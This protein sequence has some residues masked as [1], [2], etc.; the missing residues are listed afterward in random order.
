MRK[1]NKLVQGVGVNDADYKII[2]CQFYRRWKSMLLRC[3]SESYHTKQP[4]YK[5]CSV[6]KEWL[7]FSNFK[8]WMEQQG[9]EGNHLDKDLLVKGNKVYSPETCVFVN[10]TVNTFVIDRGALRGEH[11]IGVSWCKRNNKYIS[12]CRNPF[13]KK[14]DHLGYYNSPQEA[15]SAWLSRKQELCLQLC[16]TIEDKRI[17]EALKS[18]YSI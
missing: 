7:Y 9:W 14:L 12:R 18:R 10:N 3:Y 5:G 2:G 16:E 8:S 13:T 6:C 4:T 17:V 15:H 1:K 11:P